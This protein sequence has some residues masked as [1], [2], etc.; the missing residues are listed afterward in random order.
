MQEASSSSSSELVCAP[1][2]AGTVPGMVCTM[3]VVL[4]LN[5]A[6]VLVPAEGPA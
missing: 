4:R 1:H 3:V 6:Y 5:H 2:T